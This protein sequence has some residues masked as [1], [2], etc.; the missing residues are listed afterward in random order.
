MTDST[1]VRKLGSSEEE[2]DSGQAGMTNR[3]EKKTDYTNESQ[4]NLMRI[5]EY[6]GA[7]VFRAATTQEI[8]NALNLTKSKG[9][10]TLLNLEIAEWVKQEADG[11]KLGPRLPKIAEIVRAGIADNVKAFLG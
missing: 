2:K 5:V 8:C 6:L 11:W 10:W 3:K 9:Y 1:E 4:Q 7:D